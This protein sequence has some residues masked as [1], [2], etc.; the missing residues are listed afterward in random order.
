MILDENKRLVSI[1]ELLQVR[2]G[3]HFGQWHLFF[4]LPVRA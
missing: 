1:L 2:Q 4:D 3:S